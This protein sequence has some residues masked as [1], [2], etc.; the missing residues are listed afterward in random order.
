M[1]GYL[2]RGAAQRFKLRETGAE[3][4]VSS[5]GGVVGSI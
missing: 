2:G 3:E 5:S 1:N 4:W